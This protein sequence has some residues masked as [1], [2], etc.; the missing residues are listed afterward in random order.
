[1]VFTAPR[2]CWP[3]A[4]DQPSG[5]AHL[6]ENLN[7]AFELLQVRSGDGVKPIYRNGFTPEGT[8]EAVGVEVRHTID[9]CRGER[10]K[11]LRRNAENI[12]V[13][14]S[15]AWEEDGIAKRE[16]RRLLNKYT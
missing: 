13:R 14:F 9:L 1:M 3:F 15:A 10:G 11:E 8:R 16:I 12:K 5:T 2:I 4:A 6:T 7:V